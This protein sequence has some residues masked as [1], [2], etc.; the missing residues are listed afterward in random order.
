MWACFASQ[1]NRAN[2]EF[3]LAHPAAALRTSSE[4][5]DHFDD[6]GGVRS[7]TSM[8]VRDVMRRSSGKKPSDSVVL[9]KNVRPLLQLEIVR[10]LIILVK[11]TEY[12]LH[13]QYYVAVCIRDHGIFLKLDLLSR[14]MLAKRSSL[15]GARFSRQMKTRRSIV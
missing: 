2:E 4:I 9:M 11:K 5:G 6:A 13:R 12:I 8:Y 3:L 7:S 1:T 10:S 15:T 14:W